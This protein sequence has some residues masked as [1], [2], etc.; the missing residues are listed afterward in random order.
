MTPSEQPRARQGPAEDLAPLQARPRCRGRRGLGGAASGP[1]SADA[2][3]GGSRAVDYDD[4]VSASG[5]VKQSS[6][7]WYI[8]HFAGGQQYFE[9][10]T[11]EHSSNLMAFNGPKCLDC[12]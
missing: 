6:S 7:S 8:L 9:S 4:P 11:R 2:T 3:G 12:Q 1:P 10:E 5:K